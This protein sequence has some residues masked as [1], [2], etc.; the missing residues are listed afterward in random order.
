MLE[1]RYEGRLD[2]DADQMIGFITAGTRRMQRMIDDLLAFARAG[3][4]ETHREPFSL[5]AVLEEARAVL[6]AEI[7]ERGAK[8]VAGP[9]PH[10]VGDESRILQVVQNL[11]ANGIKFC[12]AERTPVIT[13]TAARLPSGWRID[14]RDNGIGIDPRYASKVFGM[15]QRLHGDEEFPGTGIGLAICQRI[16]ERHGG[17]IWV[18]GYEGEGCT[19]S[20]TIPDAGE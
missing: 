12:P 15:F 6:S 17:H 1:R 9:L 19:F 7:S 14:V 16:V 8:V 5:G 4:V 3:R 18:D 10:L 13:V 20:F 11:I 2:D